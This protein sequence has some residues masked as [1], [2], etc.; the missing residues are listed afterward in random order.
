MRYKRQIIL[1]LFIASLML[2]SACSKMINNKKHNNS[3]PIFNG[4]LLITK[5][6]KKWGVIDK[7][8][9]EIIPFICDGIKM[10]SDSIG[11]AS[12][13]SSSYSLHTGIPRY[14]YCGK[15]FLF[16]KKGRT[17]AKEKPFS[18]LI[19][20]VADNHDE[21]FI[22]ITPNRYVP[23]DTILNKTCN[24]FNFPEQK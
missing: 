11:I 12:I 6:E 21:K 19:E 4:Q 9:N 18:I 3:I 24:Q 10:I 17:N 14:V 15:Y 16:T 8:G 7:K 23:T 13:Y 5:N 2:V 22:L 20:S 1:S